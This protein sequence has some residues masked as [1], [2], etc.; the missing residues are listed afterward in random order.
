MRLLI[1]IA[2][3][4]LLA[5]IFVYSGYTMI[6]NAEGYAKRAVKAIPMLPEEPMIAKGYGAT[7][8]VAGGTFALGILPRLSARIL[9]LTVII[10][11]YIGHP[12]WETEKPEDRRPQVIHFLKNAGVLGG[13]LLYRQ[14]ARPPQTD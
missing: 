14:A 8:A 5:G 7:M 9:A 1:R 3:R 2:S 4:W 10:N 6:E 13:L 12:F 11:T